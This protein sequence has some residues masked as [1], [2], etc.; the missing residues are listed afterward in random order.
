MSKIGCIA[1]I[2]DSFTFG[3]GLE[4]YQNKPNWV[5]QRNKITHWNELQHL[6]DSDSVKFR[7][8]NRFAGIVSDYYKCNILVDSYNG[9]C[10]TTLSKQCDLILSSST[11]V[12]YAIIQFSAFNRNPIHYHLGS[13]YKKCSCDICS[14]KYIL[15]ISRIS[16]FSNIEH[17]LRKKYLTDELL[18]EDDIIYLDFF[19]NELN[20]N[21][22]N[23]DNDSNEYN[24]LSALS[25][26]DSYVY[27]Q[28]YLHI[29]YMIE[30][31][32]KPIEKLGTKVYFINSWNE[33]AEKVCDSIMKL[34]DNMLKL[35]GGTDS[36]ST[37]FYSEFEN[38]F[39]YKRISDE[40]PKTQNGH[41]TL[42]QHKHIANSI[43]AKIDND[44]F[45]R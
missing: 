26:L 45:Y 37:R 41:P 23:L 22:F 30:T 32:I 14:H 12:D 34:Q 7:E 19:N 27:T 1:F 21:I 33:S 39:K 18:E 29:H 3:E 16:C 25:Y 2:G 8:K 17:S 28:S 43:I 4:L 10:F 35:Q 31:F 20:G 5:E 24:L 40:F 11:K 42:L 36:I 9:G 44:I 38:S 15:D 13:Y 6:Q